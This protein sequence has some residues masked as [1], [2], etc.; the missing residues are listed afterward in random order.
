LLSV[1]NLLACLPVHFFQQ[2]T[3]LAFLHNNKH[4]IIGFNHIVCGNQ[5]LVVDP[6][7]GCHQFFLAL[8]G[9]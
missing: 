7:Q 4:P 6:L 3:C 2:I 9:F 8:E 5:V 1:G